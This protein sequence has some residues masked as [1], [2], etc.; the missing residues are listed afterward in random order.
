M[1]TK[2][3]HHK[4]QLIFQIILTVCHMFCYIIGLASPKPKQ[5]RTQNL[6]LMLSSGRSGKSGRIEWNRMGFIHEHA[7]RRF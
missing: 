4:A 1:E 3:T 7:G 6:A 2:P 5:T